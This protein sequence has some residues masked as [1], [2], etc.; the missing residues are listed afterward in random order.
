MSSPLAHKRILLQA[1]YLRKMR[2]LQAVHYP[3]R[4]LQPHRLLRRPQPNRLP[5]RRPHL[6]RK[7]P[8]HHRHLQ[9]RPRNHLRRKQKQHRHHRRRRRL[10]GHLRPRKQQQ[11]H[12]HHHH[13]Q[14]LQ[15]LH[16]L[17][18]LQCRHLRRKQKPCPVV[19]VLMVLGILYH[20]LLIT[21]RPQVLIRRLRLRLRLKSR[22]LPRSLPRARMFPRYRLLVPRQQVI[23]L[24]K[25][26]HH[27]LVFLHCYS[28]QHHLLQRR[29]RLVQNLQ[30]L[31]PLCLL[32]SCLLQ[33]QVVERPELVPQL[34]HLVML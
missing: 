20:Y 25:A 4:L 32:P 18:L 14:R 28:L 30:H 2:C 34:L 21:L 19:A 17:L 29:L 24:L 8:P 7:Q 31:D 9:R 16:L 12:H 6:P 27:L 33:C 11:H 3:V 15:H 22:A 23:A 1:H 13:P 26:L 5:R 10:Q